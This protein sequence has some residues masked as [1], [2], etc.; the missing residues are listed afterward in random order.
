MRYIVMKL[1]KRFKI[2][3]DLVWDIISTFLKIY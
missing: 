3:S 2:I 1:E